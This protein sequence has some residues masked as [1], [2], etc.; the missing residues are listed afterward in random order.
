MKEVVGKGRKWMKEVSCIA[1]SS[2]MSRINTVLKE[3]VGKLTLAF[4][5]LKAQVHYKIKTFCAIVESSAW[6]C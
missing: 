6:C 3:N 1:E 4:A 2:C 5:G